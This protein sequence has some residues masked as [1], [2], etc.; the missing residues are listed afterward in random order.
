M[1]SKFFLKK[2][3]TLQPGMAMILNQTPA[4]ITL[5]TPEIKGTIQIQRL[6]VF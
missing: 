5:Q 2:E 1:I 4:R 3:I 6:Y